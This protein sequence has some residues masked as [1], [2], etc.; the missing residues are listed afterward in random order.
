MAAPTSLALVSDITDTSLSELA[1][2]NPAL[3]KGMAPAGASLHVPKGSGHQLIA[4]LELVPGIHRVGP[5]ENLAAIGKRYSAAPSAILAIN[6]LAS[7]ETVEGDRLLIP[8]ATRAEAPV[9]RTA[10]RTAANS[11]TGSKTTAK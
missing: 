5:G 8:A 1:A 4:A 11:R 2:L 10:S 7:D 9:M 3:L 6:K